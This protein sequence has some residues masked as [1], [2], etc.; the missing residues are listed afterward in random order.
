VPEEDNERPP[1]TTPDTE[2]GQR[3][4]HRPAGKLVPWLLGVCLLGFLAFAL[5]AAFGALSRR[6][7]SPPFPPGSEVKLAGPGASSITVWQMGAACELGYA[8]GQV[9]PGTGARALEE[10]CRPP[11]DRET[12]QRVTLGDGTVVWV[13]AGDLVAADEYT[14]PPPTATPELE[15][16]ATPWPTPTPQPT[17][18]PTPAPLPMGS[19]L[20]AGNWAV[21]VER[22]ETV[23]SLS[24]PAGDKSVEAAGRFVLI[25]LSVTN[26]GARAGTLHASALQLQDAAGNRYGNHDQ[27]SAYASSEGCADF[28]L[29]VPPGE[30]ACLVAAIDIPVGGSPYLLY[31]PDTHQTVRLELP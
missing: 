22:V 8:F 2:G 26:Q 10:V 18:T 30:S 15:D 24:S 20:S 4:S 12:Y 5:V 11:E 17:Q 3:A 25:Y 27:A 14:P 19:V 16:T 23:A 31:L 7:P 21:R 6:T 28:A 29:D 9:P 1:V 13:A